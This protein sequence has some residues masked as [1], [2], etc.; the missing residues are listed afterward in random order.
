MSCPNVHC[1][2]LC[3]EFSSDFLA[4]ITLPSLAQNDHGYL[5]NY[6]GQWDIAGIEIFH[7]WRNEQPSFCYIYANKELQ[8]RDLVRLSLQPYCRWNDSVAYR[9]LACRVRV[10][11]SR[12]NLG[13][14]ILE[15]VDREVLC[16]DKF[17][18]RLRD[19][20][21]R[22]NGSKEGFWGLLIPPDIQY[23]VDFPRVD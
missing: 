13:S 11:T 19:K 10:K 23:I 8:F 16:R 3:H 22:T 18:L 17:L 4:L 2:T 20:L 21:Y 7:S 15:L 9:R 6:Y 12:D 14:E 5:D 1:N